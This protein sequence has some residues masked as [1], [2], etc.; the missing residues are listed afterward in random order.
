MFWGD[1]QGFLL[2]CGKVQQV[3]ETPHRPKPEFFG[4]QLKPAVPRRVRAF[5]AMRKPEMTQNI[6]T[7]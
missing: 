1:W 4:Q 6:V 2:Q 5:E 3:V 7:T